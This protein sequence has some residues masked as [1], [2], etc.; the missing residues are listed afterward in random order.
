MI[1]W[2]DR[3]TE[4][5]IMIK[6]RTTH[7]VT[8]NDGSVRIVKSRTKHDS[9]VI[10]ALSAIVACFGLC[11]LIEVKLKTNQWSCVY[12]PDDIKSMVSEG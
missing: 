6:A 9:T 8:N 12:S 5:T 1:D 11:N 7:R 10:E 2:K 3:P 4:G